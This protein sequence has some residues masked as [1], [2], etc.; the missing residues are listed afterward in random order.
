MKLTYA[1]V[2]K[3]TKKSKSKSKS[4][5]NIETE[6]VKNKVSI[7]KKKSSQKIF[8][9]QAHSASCYLKDI[10][11]HLEEGTLFPARYLQDIIDTD[12]FPK[13]RKQNHEDIEKLRTYSLDKLWCHNHTGH[14]LIKHTDFFCK[15]CLET[16]K[17]KNYFWCSECNDQIHRH[18]KNKLHSPIKIHNRIN[19]KN[20]NYGDNIKILMGQSSGRKGF[21]KTL[22]N[23]IEE[24]HPRFKK[25]L[26]KLIDTPIR[27]IDTTNKIINELNKASNKINPHKQIK[28][29]LHKNRKDTDYRVYP[30]LN[31]DIHTINGTQKTVNRYIP[32]PPN[33]ELDFDLHK[34]AIQKNGVTWPLGVYNMDDFD[35]EMGDYEILFDNKEKKD[36]FF[37][38][39]DTTK[40]GKKDTILNF[41]KNLLL[42]VRKLDSYEKKEDSKVNT[43]EILIELLNLKK[44]KRQETIIGNWNINRYNKYLYDNLFYH[45]NTLETKALLSDIIDKVIEY[46]SYKNCNNS[47]TDILFVVNQC[48]TVKVEKNDI[49]LGYGLN[50]TEDPRTNK[51]HFKRRENSGRAM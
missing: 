16:S 48:R 15:E 11:K 10:D 21:V 42:F 14:K 4:K 37:N 49:D 50:Q 6:L 35:S 23:M 47:V 2:V 30:R 39:I 1:D 31:Q 5:S 38:M 43:S 18:K 3:K 12:R 44:N 24:Y 33:I 17:G 19:I 7:K 41:K 46:E 45:N 29:K 40:K 9:I 34:N 25:L 51:F 8:I 32:G 36:S 20:M 26:T 27:K 28:K 22:F 13:Y